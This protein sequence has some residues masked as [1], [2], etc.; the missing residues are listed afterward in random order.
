MIELLL[1]LRQHMHT[2]ICANGQHLHATMRA[3]FSWVRS[4][5]VRILRYFSRSQNWP[6]YVKL[7]I[8]ECLVHYLNNSIITFLAL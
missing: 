7:T 4:L 6:I 8:V 1:V 3:D 5:V 2:C